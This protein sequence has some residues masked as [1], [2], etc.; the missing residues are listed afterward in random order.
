MT[1]VA[2][3]GKQIIYLFHGRAN[4]IRADECSHFQVLFNCHRSKNVRRLRHKAHALGHARLRAKSGDILAIQLHMALPQVKHTKHGLHSCGFTCSVRADNDCYLTAID[5]NCAVVQNIRS[6][7]IATGHRF[8]NQKRLASL[9]FWPAIHATSSL[10]LCQKNSG[11]DARSGRRGQSPL[12]ET[13]PNC[14]W[15]G[16]GT[17]ASPDFFLVLQTCP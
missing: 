4:V 6:I 1:F 3:N 2:Q 11:G 8:T 16:F 9:A 5:G 10:S 17:G 7:A 13:C 12:A 15:V 14:R